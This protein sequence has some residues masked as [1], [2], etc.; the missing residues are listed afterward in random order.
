M[1]FIWI[2]T[3]RINLALIAGKARRDVPQVAVERDNALEA[4][5]RPR[6]ANGIV[7]AEGELET[8]LD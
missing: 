8:A 6:R 4:C 2:C 3:A 7:V 5:E 1:P